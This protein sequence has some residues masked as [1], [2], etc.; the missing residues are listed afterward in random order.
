MPAP[1]TLVRAPQTVAA[2]GDCVIDVFGETEG[3]G[4]AQRCRIPL[5]ALA[6]S[7]GVVAWSA[8]TCEDLFTCNLLM[9]DCP[10]DVTPGGGVIRCR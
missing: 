10:A 3:G 7:D 8:G 9:G 6:C 5:E 4:R 1:P 2:R